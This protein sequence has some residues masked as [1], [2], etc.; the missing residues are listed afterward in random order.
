MAHRGASS[1]S[2]RAFSETQRLPNSPL[3]THDP[4]A[5]ACADPPC[6]NAA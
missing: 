6:L 4:L 2:R 3:V 5:L 1:H